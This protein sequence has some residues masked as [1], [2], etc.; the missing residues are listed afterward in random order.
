MLV[1]C[2]GF[3]Q[4]LTHCGGFGQLLTHAC[5]A[6]PAGNVGEKGVGLDDN[7]GLCTWLSSDGGSTWQDV[8]E[9]AYIYE[10]AGEWCCCLQAALR[11]P[12][13]ADCVACMGGGVRGAHGAAGPCC[14]GCCAGMQLGS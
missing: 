5:A 11:L 8:G 13:V 12:A 10:Y 4:L 14:C 7:D 9:G 2:C 1:R 3:G 6:C